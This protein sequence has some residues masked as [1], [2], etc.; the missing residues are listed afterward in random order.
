[1]ISSAPVSG[2][3]PDT[4]GV[5]AG[6]GQL[7]FLVAQ[8]VR[9]QPG[10]RLVVAAHKN[11][12]DPDLV[13]GAD[14]GIWI[15]LGQFKKVIRFF[16]QQNVK[17]VVMGGGIAK[18]GI[19]QMRPD[20]LALKVAARLKHWHD[21]HLLRA[22]ADEI[23]RHGF[24]LKGAGELVPEILAPKGIL[25]RA[26]PT[27]VQWRDVRLGWQAA[28]TLGALDVGQGVVV[29]E[30]VVLAV[31]AIEGTD[32]M[33]DRAG[34]YTGG[35]GVLVK[36]SKPGQDQRLDLPSI[37]PRTIEKLS[38]AGITVLAMEAGRTMIL[39]TETTLLAADAAGL[40]LLGCDDQEMAAAQ[41]ADAG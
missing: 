34:A 22:I 1:M 39:E 10:T 28:K 2:S 6:S 4:V 17:W 8:A 31:E 37:G 14:A 35:K 32:A 7:P 38:A 13:A 15:R 16:R 29:R 41:D 12:T 26:R 40:V 3:F 20:A 27:D 30:Q 33:I 24:E 9:R 23:E 36:V 5:I 19:W 11:E 18:V 21:D 25:T